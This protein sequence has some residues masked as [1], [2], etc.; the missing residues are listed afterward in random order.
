MIF[1]QRSHE[2]SLRSH[3]IWKEFSSDFGKILVRSARVLTSFV[4]RSLE[5]WTDILMR[6]GIKSHDIGVEITYDVLK[7]SRYVN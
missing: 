4:L 7:M 3:D 1:G 5:V 2:I 6:F